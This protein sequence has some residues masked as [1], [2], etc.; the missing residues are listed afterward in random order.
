MFD[1]CIIH[2]FIMMF[3]FYFLNSDEN[4]KDYKIK[5][6]LL[7]HCK[8]KTKNSI[9]IDFYEVSKTFFCINFF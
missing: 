2:S 5:F 3:N 8:L 1:Y 4:S 6:T 9:E 7:I